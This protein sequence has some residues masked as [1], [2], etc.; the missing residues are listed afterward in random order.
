MPDSIEGDVEAATQLI[1]DRTD[2]PAGEVVFQIKYAIGLLAVIE[3]MEKGPHGNGVAAHVAR[4]LIVCEVRVIRP[5]LDVDFAVAFGAARENQPV[6]RA[7]RAG[8]PGS[9]P[10]L[11]G[12]GGSGR[13]MCQ[14]IRWNPTG[15]S[16][17]HGAGPTA[18]S[19]AGSDQVALVR[20]R[21]GQVEVLGVARRGIP[22]FVPTVKR[23][24]DRRCAVEDAEAIEVE[25][26][27]RFAL[28]CRYVRRQRGVFVLSA[29][30]ADRE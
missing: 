22:A 26:G 19:D 2:G 20:L 10:L 9:E 13:D 8:D 12:D 7:D 11:R 28:H 4:M 15:P 18:L 23:H 14:A 24:Q 6:V 27:R 16:T 1:V 29:R 5:A 30:N 21:F 17:D 25:C 3:D